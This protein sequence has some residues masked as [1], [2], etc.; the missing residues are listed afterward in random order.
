CEVLVG[1]SRKSLIDKIIPTP[2]EERLAGTL[3]IHLKAVSNGASVVR[4]HDVREH[5]Q[6]LAVWQE[7]L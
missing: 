6:A 3:A 7:L 2:T 4:C 5:Q 1:A